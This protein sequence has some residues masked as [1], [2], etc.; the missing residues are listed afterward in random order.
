[1]FNL[2]FRNGKKILIILLLIVVGF[3]MASF[4]M[5]A[6]VDTGIDYA[7]DIGL[8]DNDP[9]VIVANVIRVAL[10][11]LGIVAVGLILYAGWLYMSA[12]GEMEKVDK[13]KKILTGAIIGLVIILSAFGIASFVLSQLLGATGSG[14]GGSGPG[15]GPG[16]PPGGGGIANSFYLNSTVPLDGSTNTVR[17]VKVRF[18]FNKSINASSVNGTNFSVKTGGVDVPGTFSVSNK[19]IQF[20]PDGTCPTNPCGA[21]NCFDSGATYTVTVDNGPS[22]V[23]STSG[24]EVDCSLGKPCSIT[25]TTGDLIDCDPP[26]A[27]LYFNSGQVCVDT[28]NEIFASAQDDSG[29]S[30]IEF[31]EGLSLIEDAV[32][33]AGAN[34]FNTSVFWDGSGYAIGDTKTFKI[35]V[36][37]LAYNSASD[38]KSTTLRAEH[39]CNGIKDADESDID[40]GGSD[41]AACAGAAC[42]ADPAVPAVC[43]DSSCASGFCS[44]S[45]SDPTS[46]SLAGYAG[47]STCCLCTNNPRIDSISPYGGFCDGDINTH[48]SENSDCSAF[49]PA[50]CNFDTPNGKEGNMVTIK[51]KYFSNTPGEVYFTGPAGWILAD[52]PSSVNP[53]CTDYWSDREVIVLIPSRAVDGPIKIVNTAD[54]LEDLTN[55]S[56][57]ALIKDFKINNITRP[58][59]CDLNPDSG[60]LNDTVNFSGNNFNSG[61]K[62]FFGNYY[63]SSEQ[64][65]NNNFLSAL[66]INSD[67]PNIVKGEVESYISTDVGINSNYLMFD[68]L[69]EPYAGP[70][71]ASFEPQEGPIGQY[72]TI[73]GSGFGSSQGTN[74]VYFD[75]AGDIKASYDF[76]DVCADSFWSDEQIIVKVP[77]GLANGDYTLSVEVNT[78]I[79]DTSLLSPN[80]FK[81]DDTIAL[82]PSLCKISPIRGSNNSEISLWGEYFSAFNPSNSKVRFHLNHDQSGSNIISWDLDSAASGIKPY[83]IETTVHQLAS[84][85][86]VRVI[87]GSPELVGN[88][89]NFE[90]GLCTKDSDCGFQICCPT[91]SIEVGRC[92]DSIDDCYMSVPSSVYEWDFSTGSASTTTPSTADSCTSLS[93]ITGSCDPVACPNSPGQ[94]SP[95]EVDFNIPCGDDYCNNTYSTE[96][97]SE[98]IFDNSLSKCKANSAGSITSSCSV[99]EGDS[100][101]VGGSSIDLPAGF[102]KAEC[103]QVGTNYYWQINPNLLSCPDLN[104]ELNING[105]CTLVDSSVSPSVPQTCSVCDSG[106]S[107]GASGANDNVGE[108]FIGGQVCPG[109]VDCVADQ[110]EVSAVSQCECCCRIGYSAQDCCAPLNCAGNCG[111]DSV[112]V[113][114][115]GTDPEV[116]G[117]CSGCRI[118]SD[119]DGSINA[120]EQALSDQACNCSTSSGKYCDVDVDVDG[121]GN[122]DGVCRDCSQLATVSS[123]SAHH[124]TCC[125]DAMDSNKCRSGEGYAGL[126][127]APDPVSAYCAYYRCD[128]DLA[129]GCYGSAPDYNKIADV[130]SYSGDVYS[131]ISDCESQCQEG[132][133]PGSSCYDDTYSACTLTCK[134]GYNCIGYDGCAGGLCNPYDT[135]C[136]CCCDPGDPTAS[137]PI[138]PQVNA[139]GLECKPDKAPCDGANRGLYCGCS[140]DSECG[141]PSTVG[142]AYD[143]CCR[144]RAE[145]TDTY[146][147]DGATSV[148][149]N[150]LISATFDQKMNISSFSGNVIVVGDYGV[151]PCPSNTTY[152]ATGNI[153][154]KNIFVRIFNKAVNNFKNNLSFLFN[155]NTDRAIAYT[156]PSP[157]NHYCAIK[158]NVEGEHIGTDSTKIKFI[159]EDVLDENRTYY[160]IVKGDADL[161]SANGVLNDWNIGYNGPDTET[162][163]GI[164]YKN[165]KI[166]QFT[167]GTDICLLDSVSIDP[168]SKLFQ[169]VGASQV[170]S[171]DYKTAGGDSIVPISGIYNWTKD[172]SINNESVVKFSGGS[173]ISDSSTQT[174][175]AQNKQDAKTF[176]NAK[177]IISED[178]VN[179]PST[180]GEEKT[181]KANIYVFLCQNPWPAIDA[182]G[183]WEPWR[184]DVEGMSCIPGS[185]TCSNTNY[186]LY[187]CRDSGSL[188][189]ADD[190]PALKSDNAVI[191]GANLSLTCSEAS[192]SCGAGSAYG[193]TCGSSGICIYNN[194]VLKETYFFREDIPMASVTDD[195][196]SL[197]AVNEG[198]G[199]KVT[200]KWCPTNYLNTTN[201]SFLSDIENYDVYYSTSPNIYLNP[202]SATQLAGV[203][204]APLTAITPIPTELI[205]LD[206]HSSGAY[207]YDVSGLTNGSD[208]YFAIKAVDSSAVESDFSNEDD[209]KPEDTSSPAA[210]VITDALT[211]QLNST[212]KIKWNLVPGASEYTLSYVAGS[213]SMVGTAFAANIVIDSSSNPTAFTSGEFS[214]SNTPSYTLFNGLNYCFSV[215]AADSAGNY[216]AYAS[217][218]DAT[219]F[220]NL[221]PLGGSFINTPLNATVGDNEVD[222][223]WT[224]NSGAKGYKIIVI[225]STAY[226]AVSPSPFEAYGGISY[227]DVQTSVICSSGTC[228]YKVVNG[229]AGTAC[230]APEISDSGSGEGQ[231]AC[232]EN[233][234][235]LR[236]YV[237]A[238]GDCFKAGTSDV[239]YSPLSDPSAEVTPTSTS[240][241]I[242]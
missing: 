143:T 200:L 102:S 78:D 100:F 176:I 213:C 188:N 164:E 226:P 137:P 217:G 40:C 160:V 144:T 183:V 30:N 2:M 142:C 81:V 91:D 6:S 177:A 108:C 36:Y 138:P 231:S 57:G 238:L 227:D 21:T 239:C 113:A 232:V 214:V 23:L 82:S 27:S 171:A 64:G 110:C 33:P 31:Y 114:S 79:A 74:H 35:D 112:I 111:A 48:C 5:A 133:Y 235:T 158:G 240:P 107:C 14:P 194:D 29:I 199:G 173:P 42:A 153:K 209:A 208:Y 93:E 141:S 61:D 182:F 223:T 32:N 68:K 62:A 103:K 155:K 225:P 90:V 96:C 24:L 47:A 65:L 190:L 233:G 181:G 150:N 196:I 234:N 56:N 154:P 167:T 77:D 116:Y 85:G 19:T 101:S 237:Q 15:G 105:W 94:C 72:I 180:I 70:G 195:I 104:W 69:E 161:D 131:A 119:G 84:S 76:P 140:S 67:V 44:S 172:W 130:G 222:L 126:L 8:G 58:G 18:N 63:G 197:V 9:R 128:D 13:A 86:G 52:M 149:R 184:D 211:G 185:G 198:S 118:D 148:C 136:A 50:T 120:A 51:G 236:F 10:G 26:L 129:N 166:W 73:K 28:N 71:I 178:T 95:G 7:E 117:Q 87:K 230:T 60:V 22:G 168:A 132:G 187:Y 220:S 75:Y 25:F 159:T 205:G 127:N 59:L 151:D 11:F 165:S 170:F 97:A 189:T 4:A 125:A 221:I 121:D 1:M 66:N 109:G 215:K 134:T 201:S 98:C 17:N 157:S 207:Q 186:E 20:I 83:K 175:E 219:P 204:S 206:C 162:F 179:T 41:C 139:E 54:S 92:M 99:Y 37:D 123:C 152:I 12:A 224:D 122:P 49:S 191:R 210:P 147:V 203:L 192:G 55:D 156:S 145:V 218:V 39:C 106:F 146:P 80:K 135:T 242:P 53:M 124:T 46:C 89:I 115:G 34:P 38:S 43:D 228:N 163:N 3:T 216:S 16:I 45:G 174:V 202:G 241:I 193:D 88:S 169:E 212:V 229:G